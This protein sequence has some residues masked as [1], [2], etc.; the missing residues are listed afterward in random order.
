MP[1]LQ[2]MYLNQDVREANVLRNLGISHR[3]PDK[4]V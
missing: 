1:E 2:E 4:T 3:N